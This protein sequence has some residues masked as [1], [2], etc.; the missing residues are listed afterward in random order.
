MLIRLTPILYLMTP[1]GLAEAHFLQVHESAEVAAV[2]GTFIIETKENWFW[3]NHQV[4]LCESFTADRGGAYTPF[5]LSADMLKT[6]KPHIRRHKGSPF[7]EHY[8]E[9]NKK[10][11]KRNPDA[12]VRKFLSEHNEESDGPAVDN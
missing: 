12:T 10:R 8:Q 7:Y 3:P 2:W 11:R 9:D 6:L 5:H 4:R 1:L